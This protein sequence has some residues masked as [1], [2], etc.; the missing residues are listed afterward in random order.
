M[1][2]EGCLH[3]FFE[4]FGCF[5][6]A[7]FHFFPAFLVFGFAFEFFCRR[8]QVIV[9][10]LKFAFHP[11][12]G[13]LHFSGKKINSFAQFPQKG[14]CFP[15]TCVF[16]TSCGYFLYQIYVALKYTI[17][18]MSLQTDPVN[19]IRMLLE[20]K[21]T[22]KQ[23]TFK[24]LLLAFQ[25][26]QTD[27]FQVINEIKKRARPGDQDVTTDFIAVNDHE[28]QVKL[29]GDL[30]VFV[31][32]TNIVTFQDDHP[33]L[34]TGYM[35]Q[36]QVNRYFGQIMI[37]NFMSDSVRFNRMNDPGYL[38]AR[39]LINHEGRYVIEGD[40]PL[41]QFSQTVSEGSIT[42][43]ELTNLVKIALAMAIENDLVAP[44]F[45]QVRFITL[46]QK[47][48]KTQELGAG[49]KIGF[50]MSYQNNLEG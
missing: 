49:Q 26:L 3:G 7:V 2:A 25:T 45:P 31:L 5:L 28:F 14:F 36:Q 33:I 29:A 19:T 50:R 20:T 18:S 32:H 17:T 35:R 11:G 27:A 43:L 10:L 47:L 6:Q 4:L 24:N 38:L 8:L 41:A 48:E 37:Y 39:L 46:H 16:H 42:E 40:G 34:Q 21:S 30:L 1:F 15:I 22:A 13:L 44:P 12:A 9:A 23:I